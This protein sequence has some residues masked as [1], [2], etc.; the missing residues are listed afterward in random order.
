MAFDI[1]PHRETIRAEWVDYNGHLRDAF[2]ALIFS[3]ATD[4]LMDRIGLDAAGR[5][6]DHASVYTLECHI[7][8]LHEVEEGSEVEVHTQLLGADAKRLHIYHTMVLTGQSEPV[9]ASEQ[10][11][12]HVDTRGPKSVVFSAQV[13]PAVQALLAAH[14][15]LAR[16]S[17]AGRVIRLP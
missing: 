2:Y 1:G 4:A 5:A 9:A 17:H 11:L 15:G 6:R 3:Y 10:M 14:A 13:M 8:F 12:L 7:N 16:P